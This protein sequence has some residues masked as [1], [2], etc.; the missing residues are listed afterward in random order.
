MKEKEA[1]EK[2]I[3]IEALKTEQTKLAKNISTKDVFNFE[4]ATRFGA[5]HTEILQ[6]TKEIMACAAVCDENLELIEEKYII[7]PIKFPYIPG[8]RAYRE[9]I[10][11]SIVYSKLEEQPDVIFIEA[12]GIAHPRGLGLTSHFG[13]SINKPTIG[14]AKKVLIGEEKNGE[15]ILNKKIVAKAIV[16]KQG[17]N[18]VYISPGHMISLKT[19][20]EVTKRCI[21][22][23]HKMPEPI[24]LARKVAE[25]VKKELGKK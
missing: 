12:H 16:T 11:M 8:Y 4:N 19:A 14:V 24:V 10:P 22:E 15:I 23:P 9:L 6:K 20:I 25:N 3:D 18:P 17:A 13:V 2:G 7:K 1:I 21:K 5:I